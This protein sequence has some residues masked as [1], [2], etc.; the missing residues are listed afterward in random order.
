VS[1]QQVIAPPSPYKGLAP[2][3]D[4]SVDALFFFGR[5]RE[6]EIVASNLLAY[7]LTVLYGASGVGKSSL[8]RAGVAYHLRRQGEAVV[9][10]STWSGDPDTSLVADAREALAACF[11]DS[12][13]NA[14]GEDLSTSFEGWTRGLGR[15]LYLILDQLDE[16]FLYHG[17]DVGFAAQL[18]EVV[19]RPGL[20]VNV[21][22][23]LRDDMLSRLDRFKALIPNL[24]SNYL[25]LDHLDRRGAREAIVGPLDQYNALVPRD[26]RV[27][28]EPEL[29]AAVLDQT[30]A[31]RVDSG[32]P[33]EGNRVEAPYLQLVMQRLWEE[34]RSGGSR[35]LRLETL[36]RLGGADE[37]VRAHLSEALESLSPGD[38]DLAAKLFNHLVTP[39]GTK[40]SH[41]IGDLAQYAAVSEREVAPVLAALVDERIVRPVTTPGQQDGSRYEIFHDVLAEPVVAWRSK[42]EAERERERSHEQARRRNRRLLAVTIVS[43]IAV[44]SMVLVTIF[45]LA[46][47]R[48]ARRQRAEA[49]AQRAQAQEQ[50]RS[51]RFEELYARASSL[52]AT[53]PQRSLSGA[54]R[55]ARLEPNA[56]IEGV[57]R[58]AILQSPRALV[59]MGH[60]D[61]NDVAFSHN[62]LAIAGGGD[63]TALVFST[64]GRV[65]QTLRH[66]APINAVLLTRNGSQAVTAGGNEVLIWKT[67]TGKRLHELPVP[68]VTDVALTLD[69][70]KLATASADGHVGVWDMGSGDQAVD[71]PVGS[72]V[73]DVSLSHDGNL[74]VVTAE[75][76]ARIY[77]S[78]GG[79]LVE[80]PHEGVTAAAFSPSGFLAATASRDRTAQIW[81]LPSGD[82]PQTLAGYTS[83]LLDVEFSPGGTRLVTANA[84]GTATVW[85]EGEGRVSVISGH[86]DR[87]T[88]ASFS[89]DGTLVLTASDDGTAR[90]SKAKT[91]RTFLLFPGSGHREPVND[92]EFSPVGAYVAT[93][94]GSGIVRLWD[95]RPQPLPVLVGHEPAPITAIAVASDGRRLVDGTSGGRA[96]VWQ[97]GR[98]RRFETMRA[99]GPILAADF[100]SQPLVVVSE[101]HGSTLRSVA[102]RRL[103]ATVP[104]SHR[105]TAAAVMPG[106]RIFA[107]ARVRFVRLWGRNGKSLPVLKAP[108]DVTAVALSRDGR[109]VAAAT[110]SGLAVAWN[111]AT[112]ERLFTCHAGGKALISIAFDSTADRVLTSSEDHTM[113]ICGARTGHNQREFRWHT[114]ASAIAAAFS[115]DDRWI[116]TA[117]PATAGLGLA[118]SEDPLFRLPVRKKDAPLTS[119]AWAP[120]GHRIVTG[121]SGG[122]IRTYDCSVCGG[123]RELLQ[124]AE[125]RLQKISKR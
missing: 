116:A 99:P 103:L 43:L 125:K 83:Q 84:D 117:G 3:E 52:L 16:Y 19:T 93:A 35:T 2:F 85:N 65:V 20:R 57:L 33:V 115:A 8:L 110:D 38:R 123:V 69:E 91:G 79:L 17:D 121:D 14:S 64:G 29:V 36:E 75:G 112:G 31:G 98:R 32:E 70:T 61:V 42:H 86:T 21:L 45:A 11:P 77:D 122:G 67:E 5:E 50:E 30:I 63:G 48:E 51:A 80:L 81:S 124:I 22:L 92:A 26:D 97:I 100:A 114:S 55:A 88:L 40:I 12:D 60:R 4:S 53:D 106:G 111:V 82:L 89:P 73:Q 9:V 102:P 34:E 44:A 108:A 90:V 39:S 28:A 118:G 54:V 27:T 78:S 109:R 25:R 7:R 23:S 10:F 105:P 15:D 56:R 94:G 59:K 6:R 37:I 24:L 76:R 1:E 71:I 58:S 13:L 47:R 120:R 96:S 18:A 66:G 46:Q 74:L 95:A 87:I 62:D 113:R 107:T 72:A 41:G 68:K 119:V 49:Q 101:A 104:L